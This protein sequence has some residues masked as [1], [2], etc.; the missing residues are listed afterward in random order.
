MRTRRIVAALAALAL[1]AG[2]T[3][4]GDDD[5][6]PG[7]AS[8]PVTTPADPCLDAP[9]D[10]S[11]V[12]VTVPSSGA[13]VGPGFEVTGCS[14][15][16]ESTITWRLLDR[17]GDVLAEGV[18]SGGGV[19]GPGPFAFRVDYAAPTPEQVGHLEVGEEDASDGEGFPPPRDVVP[20]TL[21]P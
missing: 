17:A 2:A 19:D 4:C 7:S 20:L 16:F 9:A 6:D 15:T 11:L 8:A 13:R 1:M 3:A 10:A 5:D 14:R 21:T 18:G 12:F